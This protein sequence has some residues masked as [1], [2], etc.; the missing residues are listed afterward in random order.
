MVYNSVH[1]TQLSYKQQLALLKLRGVN[2]I[3]F[4][5]SSKNISKKKHEMQTKNLYKS[6]H[7]ISSIGYYQLKSFLIPYQVK[8]KVNQY[9][10]ID[11]KTLINRYYADKRLRQHILH[12]IEDIEV[13][14]NTKIAHVLGEQC[15]AENFYN[16][17]YWCQINSINPYLKDDNG[18]YG[19]YMSRDVVEREKQDLLDQIRPKLEK[20]RNPD[21]RRYLSSKTESD[22]DKVAIW[23]LMNELTLGQTITIFKLMWPTGRVKIANYFNCSVKTL[24]SWLQCLNLIRNICCHNGNLSDLSLVT[25]PHIPQEFLNSSSSTIKKLNKKGVNTQLNGKILTSYW[26][27]NKHGKKVQKYTNKLAIPVIIIISLMR[28]VNPKYNFGKLSNSIYNL[29]DET[30]TIQYY[31]FKNKHALSLLFSKEEHSD[32][33]RVRKRNNRAK[34]KNELKYFNLEASSRPKKFRKS[35]NNNH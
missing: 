30:A 1:K 3:S 16:F 10:N 23:M 34:L 19:L 2:G 21:L 6:L 20:S 11:F 13:C 18:N 14:L 8:G 32:D 4:H 17:N 33:I 22:D 26:S 12:A 27:Y 29:V 9:S 7:Q 28:T 25:L 5:V 24:I 15:G 31:G 35:K